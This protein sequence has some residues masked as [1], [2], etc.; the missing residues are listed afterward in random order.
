NTYSIDQN[1]IDIFDLTLDSGRLFTEEEFHELDPT[2]V[3]VLMGSDYKDYFSIGD[4]FEGTL[5]LKGTPMTFK[6]IGFITNGQLFMRPGDSTPYS[7][8]NHIILPHITKTVPEWLDFYEIN[9]EYVGVKPLMWTMYTNGLGTTG[10]LTRYFLV[11]IGK[12]KEFTIRMNEIFDE[13]EDTG[14][15]ELYGRPASSIQV[16]DNVDEK[17]ALLTTLVLIMSFFAVASIIF[18]AINNASNNMKAYAIHSLVGA[19]RIQIVL[20][21]V[22]ETFIYC[23]SGFSIGFFY[24]LYSRLYKYGHMNAPAALI[25]IDKWRLFAVIFTVLSCILSLIFVYAK[26]KNY[27]IAELIR[28]RDVRKTRVMPLYKGITFVMFLLTSICITFLTSYSWQV[29]HV[30][31]YQNNF[32]GKTGYLVYITSEVEEKRL[33]VDFEF[34]IDEVE[35]YSIDIMVNLTYRPFETPR[36]RGW[37][38]KGDMAVPEVTWGRFFTDEELSQTS[39]YAVVGKNAFEEFGVEEN[40]KKTIT[41][42]GRTYEVIGICGREGH[43]TTIDDW[44]FITVPTAL[45]RHITNYNVLLLIDGKNEED[46]FAVRDNIR[47]QVEEKYIYNE[48]INQLHLDLGVS[49]YTLQI[50]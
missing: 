39:D 33:P 36:V 25:A 3:P 6:V 31:R 26:V 37:Y 9:Q 29:E 27:S 30:D 35:D 38:K 42:E 40:G 8:N 28:G 18:S 12:E 4:T 43:N 17:N 10:M 48:V 32:W 1:F 49:H 47:A 13:V 22:I 24:W 21:S 15:F 23:I 7:F 44:V 19:T 45:K 16:A 2:C 34:Y 14:Y 11:E 46:I 20:Y 50:F 5:F 41:Y